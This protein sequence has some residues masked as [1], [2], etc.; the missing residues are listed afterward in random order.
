[1]V[2]GRPHL[3]SPGERFKGLSSPVLSRSGCIREHWG[4]VRLY[5]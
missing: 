5:R 3:D 2:L 1:V 4:M